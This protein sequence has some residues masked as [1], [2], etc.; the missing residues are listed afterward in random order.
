MSGVLE[1]LPAELAWE[2][3]DPD[4]PLEGDLRLAVPGR[5]HGDILYLADPD[6]G[7]ADGFHQK[8]QPG[9]SACGVQQ[10]VIFLPGQLPALIPEHPPLEPQGTDPATLPAQKNTKGRSQTPPWN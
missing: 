4:F 10:T 2:H 1:E 6:A 3:D 7:G 9:L 5:L 8:R